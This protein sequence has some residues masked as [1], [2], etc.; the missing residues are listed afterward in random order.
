MP[1]SLAKV[2]VKARGA[3][4]KF[5]DHLHYMNRWIAMKHFREVGFIRIRDVYGDYLS[6]KVAGASWAERAG[7]FSRVT[8]SAPIVRLVCGPLPT[9]WFLNRAVYLIAMK[10]NE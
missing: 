1:K 5:L 6:G 2:Y 8:W 4:P 10:P 7:R 3:Y 9:A